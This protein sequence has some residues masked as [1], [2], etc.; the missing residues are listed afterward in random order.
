MRIVENV[1]WTTEKKLR[2]ENKLEPWHESCVE[3]H[4]V[5]DGDRLDAIGAFGKYLFEFSRFVVLIRT[6]ITGILRTAAYNAAV[7]NPLYVPAGDP[8][9]PI[10]CVQHFHDKLLH[11]RDRLKTPQGRALAAQRHQLVS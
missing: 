7:N 9:E 4:C 8:R 10:S 3:L 11:V 6:W 2:A 1:S 5:Q